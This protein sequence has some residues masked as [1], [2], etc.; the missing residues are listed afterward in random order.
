MKRSELREHIFRMLF[1]VEFHSEEEYA[2]QIKFYIEGMAEPSEADVAYLKEK[3]EKVIEK[4]TELDQQVDD[5]VVGWKTDRMG[6]VDLTI[7]RLALYE[8]KYDD[9]VPAGVAINEAVD[10]AKRYG[11][12]ESASFINGVLARFV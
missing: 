2:E 5:V 9:D 11:T 7:I 12:T 6:R 10:L 3:T 4:I 8:I 1:R